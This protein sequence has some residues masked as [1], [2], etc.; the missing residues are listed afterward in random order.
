MNFPLNIVTSALNKTLQD[1]NQLD[2]SQKKFNKL[3]VCVNWLTKTLKESIIKCLPRIDVFLH[4]IILRFIKNYQNSLKN[5][6]QIYMVEI[7]SN[8]E[9]DKN[10]K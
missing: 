5:F 9:F 1:I 4:F 3:I 2:Q 7:K 10:F 6:I 8:E